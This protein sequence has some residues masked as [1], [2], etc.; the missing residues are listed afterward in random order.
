M[1][2]FFLMVLLA[3][4][5]FTG[6]GGMLR[7]TAAKFKS[8]ERALAL[9]QKARQAIGGESSIAGINSLIVTGK[10]TRNFKFDGVDRSE[11][12]EME[13][14]LQFPDKMIKMIKIG[15]DDGAAGEKMTSKQ[16]DVVVVRNGEG[17]AEWKT[18][19][20]NKILI[21]KDDGTV[22]EVRAGGDKKFTIRKVDGTPGEVQVSGDKKVIFDREV[23]DGKGELPRQGNELLRTSLALLLTAPQGMDVSYIYAGEGNVDGAACNIIDAQFAGGSIKL[24]LGRD[25]NL[26]VMISYQ[27][28][29]IPVMMWRVKKDET[30]VPTADKD[31]KVFTRKMEAPEMAEFQVKFSDYRSVNGVLLPYRWTQTAGGQQDESVEISSY[32][33]N[34]ANIGD[35][36]KAAGDT[37]VFMRKAK[38]GN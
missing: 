29:K 15:H 27:G 1:K 16:V 18:E 13:I 19:G 28:A 31:V 36:L 6:L 38:E 14:A 35:K 22:E 32:E 9:L 17:N 30:G 5:F 7:E 24:Y 33:I 25:S 3:S 23:K 4:V 34:P 20:G 26:P 37:K 21:K 11:Q 8:D 10:T 12:G 2:K